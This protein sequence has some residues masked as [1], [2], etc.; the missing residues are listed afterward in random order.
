LRRDAHIKKGERKMTRIR[1]KT[2][3]TAIA[4]I[5]MLTFAISLVA[6]PAAN[7]HTPPWKIT[8]FAYIDA[9]PNPVG[10]GQ[11]INIYTWLNWPMPGTLATNDIRFHDYKII[12]TKPDNTTSEIVIPVVWDPTSS[13]YT[14]FTPEEVG[15]Y[16]IVFEF[17]GQ[18]YDFG[19]AYQGD[20][21]LAATSKTVKLIV[22]EEEIPAPISS[23]PL[24]TEYWVE[25]I[26]GQ[27]TAWHTIASNWLGQGS[28]K[29]R[30]NPARFQMDGIAPNSAH[31]MWYRPLGDGGIVGGDFAAKETEGFYHGSSYQYRF[32]NPIIMYGRLFYD[33]EYGN[34]RNGGGYICVD[35]RTG[36]EIWFNDQI[37]VSGSGVPD[38]SFGYYYAYDFYNQHGV[39]PNGWLFSNNFGT[40]VDPL[41]G[42]VANLHITNVPSGYE[43]YGPSGEHIRYVWDRTGQWLAQ[44]NSSKV[45][46]EQTSGTIP[47]NCP[48][49]PERPSGRYWNG[50]DWV[51][52]SVRNQQGYASVTSPAFDWNVSISLLPAGTSMQ[53]AIFD[54]VL[55]G[56]SNLAG[57]G[58]QGTPDP[59]TAWALSLKPN[60]RGQLMWQKDYPAPANNVT[61]RTIA[62]DQ[63]NRVFI[64]RDKETLS[65]VG[66]SLD[67]G[68]QLWQTKPIEGVSD[69]EY[70][71][72]TFLAT[73]SVAAYG[74]LYHAGYAGILYCYDG[75][76]GDLLWTYGNGGPGNT[77]YAGLASPYGHYPIYVM[78]IADRKVYIG[79]G[80]HSADTP[81]Y[82]GFKIRCV[83]A[84]TGEEIWTLPGYLGYPGAGR[85]AVALADG[86]FT[87]YNGYDSQVYCVGKGPSAT[88]VTASPKVSVY[89]DNVLVEG[90][91]MDIAAGTKQAEQAARFPYG[92][93]AVSD[94]SQKDWMEYLYMQK[95]RPMNA[96]GVDV[97]LSVL[98]SNGNYRDIGTVTSDS[99]GFFSYQWTPDIP[100][101]FEV[102]ASFA[103]SESYWPSHAVTAFGVDEAPEATPPPTPE[104]ASAADLYFI[105]MSI[106][107]LIAIVVV[108]ALIIL[109]ML[110]KR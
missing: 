31:V 5:L 92:V 34:S 47:A 55:L 97:T 84:T 20:I 49:T 106:G 22:Q 46:V 75:A 12:I 19:G 104:P 76:T 109:L 93:P 42:K 72:A 74:N 90:T 87:F 70:Y 103:G 16:S 110:R 50:S 39:I 89:G 9:E 83:N 73:M 65:S 53:A 30:D 6:L 13:A 2:M 7:A 21:F 63:V 10:V 4:F 24:P 48:I 71:D 105:P 68:S 64:L 88:T 62:L 59:Y 67:D 3:A 81:L 82:K 60:S 94:E 52:S 23:F 100:G 107:L 69:F 11:T 101:K 96:T 85:A 33:V 18:T 98:D 102:F 14:P 80:E 86:Y 99:D 26:E 25:P 61:R 1:S 58:D 35:L 108:G 27:N 36:E 32:Y 45:F 28:P 54:D 56:L 95:P 17:P 41:T 43:V 57:I 78:G 77:T 79:A 29:Y 37:A 66:F 91:V 51:T 40:A 8:P 15:T 38:I 44:W